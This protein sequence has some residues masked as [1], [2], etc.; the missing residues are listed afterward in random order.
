MKGKTVDKVPL[1]ISST[2]YMTKE[3]MEKR[4]EWRKQ[5]QQ[6]VERI[7]SWNGDSTST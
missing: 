7:D 5:M 3:V 1:A 6:I 4:F 2:Q